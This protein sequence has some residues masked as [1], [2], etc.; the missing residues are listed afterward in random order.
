MDQPRQPQGRPTGG[1]YAET[2]R[3]DSGV[4]LATA[5]PVISTDTA[6][7]ARL[8]P[9]GEQVVAQVLTPHRAARQS[10]PQGGH[11][12]ARWPGVP[13]GHQ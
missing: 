5:P 8:C 4:G 13:G 2:S 3:P 9:Q 1:Q 6:T 11:R 10:A 12:W 7:G